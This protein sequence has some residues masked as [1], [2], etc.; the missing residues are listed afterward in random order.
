MIISFILE[1]F[2][3]VVWITYAIVSVTTSSIKITDHEQTHYRQVGIKERMNNVK[4]CIKYKTWRQSHSFITREIKKNWPNTFSCWSEYFLRSGNL[5]LLRWKSASRQRWNVTIIARGI[6]LK[7]SIFLFVLFPAVFLLLLEVRAF[8]AD[9]FAGLYKSLIE[10]RRG[11]PALA[12]VVYAQSLIFCM[13][14]G[15]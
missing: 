11:V 14:C 13:L 9:R 10:V 4:K 1:V 12:I 2:K 3:V 8:E 15:I 7:Y 6:A 5:S